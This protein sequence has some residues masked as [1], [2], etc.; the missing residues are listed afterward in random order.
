MEIISL[1]SKNVNMSSDLLEVNTPNGEIVIDV[2]SM[3][4]EP[5]H[6][7]SAYFNATEIAKMFNVRLDNIFRTKEWKIIGKDKITIRGTSKSGT[8][9]PLFLLQDFFRAVL[10]FDDYLNL[11]KSGQLDVIKFK[12]DKSK[13][14]Y[15]ILADDNTIKIGITTNIKRRFKQIKNASG[16]DI[17]NFIYTDLLSNA[18]NIEQFLLHYF[19]DYRI[20]GEWLQGVEFNVVVK[21]LNDIIERY[22]LNDIILEDNKIKLIEFI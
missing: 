11:I 6:S 15:I 16:K 22:Y 20:H 13:H 19:D 12:I 9:L 1:K 17:V 5:L 8:W 7:D 14:V 21:K 3:L 2:K 18:Y 10:T 4:K